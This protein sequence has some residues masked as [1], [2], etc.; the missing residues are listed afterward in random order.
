MNGGTFLPIKSE[1]VFDHKM[2]F[3]YGVISQK[4]ANEINKIRKGG[5]KIF[6]VGT[7][8]LR[9]LES[10]KDS[11]GKY[12]LLVVKQISLLNLVQKLILLTH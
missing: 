10:S 8:V 6:A 3:E 5:G 11:K 9:L 4:A 1:N 7:T 12:I 2:H